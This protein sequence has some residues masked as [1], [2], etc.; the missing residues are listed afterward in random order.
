MRGN[1]IFIQD[2][3]AHHTYQK[4][5]D[6]DSYYLRVAN[7]INDSLSTLWFEEPETND[8]I[9][10]DALK[11]LSIYLTCYL[12]DVIANTGIFAAFRTI[13]KEL[14][15]Q[16]YLSARTIIWWITILKISIAKM[17]RY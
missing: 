12:E 15:N 13:H 11:T 2:W 4:A 16:F 1:R 14:Y 17:S 5:N 7:Q 9:H 10:T 6:I 8:L 3:I